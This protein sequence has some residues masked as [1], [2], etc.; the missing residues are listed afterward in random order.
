MCLATGNLNDPYTE[1][2]FHCVLSCPCH[3]EGADCGTEA[4]GHCPTGAL[5]YRALR[6]RTHGVCGYERPT[7]DGGNSTLSR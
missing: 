1:G 2:D 6:L 4:H 7:L 5:C 3:G